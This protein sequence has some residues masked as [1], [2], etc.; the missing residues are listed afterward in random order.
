MTDAIY[1][2]RFVQLLHKLD[3]PNFSTIQYYN[4]VLTQAMTSLVSFL[5]I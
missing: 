1:C 5:A 2:A 3:T 4:A